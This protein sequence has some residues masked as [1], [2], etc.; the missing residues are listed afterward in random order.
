[1]DAREQGL[2]EKETKVEVIAGDYVVDSGYFGGLGKGRG[3]S[4]A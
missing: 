4:M 3:G 2:R 1:M